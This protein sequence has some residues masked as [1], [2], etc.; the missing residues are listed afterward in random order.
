MSIQSEIVFLVVV[1]LILVA[2][3]FALSRSERRMRALV[4]CP[5]CCLPHAEALWEWKYSRSN[6]KLFG[7]CP[8]CLQDSVHPAGSTK[9]L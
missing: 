9:K 5:S 6:S 1:V 7:T 4:V 8:S 3:K 2:I